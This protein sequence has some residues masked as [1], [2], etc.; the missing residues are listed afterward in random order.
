MLAAP[1]GA[2]SKLSL[3]LPK[4]HEVQFGALCLKMRE[5][6]LNETDAPLPPRRDFGSGE[7]EFLPRSE[8]VLLRG[9]P[10][11]PFRRV[12]AGTDGIFGGTD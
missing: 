5:P 6:T 12:L 4:N 3:W 1:C 9:A 11:P 2:A 8:L 7:V 10:T